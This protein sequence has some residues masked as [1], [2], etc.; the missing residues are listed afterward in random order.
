MNERKLRQLTELSKEARQLLTKMIGQIGVGHV[1]GSLSLIEALVYL[2]YEEMRV[3]PEE[4]GWPDR[5]RIVLSKGHAGPALYTLLAMKG[6]FDK[7]TLLTLNQPGTRLPSH[8]DMKLT[9]GIDMTAGSLG[10]GLSAAVGMALA[11]RME[12]KDYRVYCI[13]GDGEQQEGQIWEAAMYAGSQELDNLVVLVD[14]NGMQIDDY[15]DAI[16]AVR[17]LDKRWEAFGWATLCIDGHNFSDLEAA[18]TH[19][20]TIKK[21]PPP[22]SSW[23]RSRAKGFR[24]RKASSVRTTCPCRPKTS[25]PLCRNSNKE[26]GMPSCLNLRKCVR[27]IAIR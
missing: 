27:S 6:Y 10:Q 8:C 21:R 11:A 24:S 23:P 20:R 1:G 26:R 22:P 18:L 7:E 17:P 15:T 25:P 16:N 12:R 5:D 2:Y 19:A 13:V 14:D 4:P 3:R 9:T